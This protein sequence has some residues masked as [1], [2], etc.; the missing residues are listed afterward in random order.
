M[1]TVI[2]ASS[3]PRIQSTHQD[4]AR[5]CTASSPPLVARA[6]QCFQHQPLLPLT[7]L[8]HQPQINLRRLSRDTMR[9]AVRVGATRRVVIIGPL[10]FKF[11]RVSQ[12]GR[13]GLA[14]RQAGGRRLFGSS[15]RHGRRDRGADPRLADLSI[16]AMTCGEARMAA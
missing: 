10:A 1:L 11:A 14:P 6:G 8:C 5:H 7:R 12:A 3:S 4:S 9:F 15:H 13:L 2:G 16:L